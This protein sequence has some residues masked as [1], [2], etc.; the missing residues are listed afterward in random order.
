[1]RNETKSDR[2]AAGDAV[3]A[4]AADFE[5]RE[6]APDEL[7][8]IERTRRRSPR[9]GEAREPPSFFWSGRVSCFN[10]LSN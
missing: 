5:K 1:M 6:F 3:E 8:E 9:I 10:W 2:T 7:G 4:M